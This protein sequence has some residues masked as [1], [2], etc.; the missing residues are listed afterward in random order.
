MAI[1][2]LTTTTISI[3]TTGTILIVQAIGPVQELD[4]HKR[5]GAEKGD[6]THHIGVTPPMEMEDPPIDSVDAVPDSSR[7]AG[8]L[9]GDRAQCPRVEL[10][11]PVAAPGLQHDHLAALVP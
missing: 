11:V 1:S 2:T 6:I 3:A 7:D 5:R 4:L 10:E 9:E 8:L